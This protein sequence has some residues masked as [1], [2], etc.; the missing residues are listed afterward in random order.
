MRCG[1][2]L[3]SAR[4]GGKRVMEAVQRGPTEW[5]E[6]RT[7]RSARPV[8]S[9]EGERAGGGQEASAD[10]YDYK[11]EDS[12]FSS[13][14]FMNKLSAPP[15]AV[16][17]ASGMARARTTG[18]AASADTTGSSVA[19]ALRRRLLRRRMATYIVAAAAE[20]RRVAQACRL[21]TAGV[22]VR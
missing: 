4:G 22:V 5:C 14:R 9:R 21:P 7:G 1:R 19:S 13:S 20:R 18:E 2:T 12:Y 17:P 15:I 8:V 16:L 11:R 10:D 3:E 6:Q